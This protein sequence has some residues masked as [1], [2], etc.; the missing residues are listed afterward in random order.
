[1][2]LPFLELFIL[3]SK[4]V[5]TF[6]VLFSSLLK[7]LFFFLR[8]KLFLKEKNSTILLVMNSFSFYMSKEDFNA[9]SFLKDIFTGYS[10]LGWQFFS[11]CTFKILL[12]CLLT[13][14]VSNMKSVTFI[15]VPF[16]EM[17]LFS[18]VAFQT[19]SF[20]LVLSHFTDLVYF[21]SC[22]LC[23]GLIEHLQFVNLV[24]LSSTENFGPLCLNNFCPPAD[25]TD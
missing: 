1:M 25:F 20:L 3:C 5:F 4:F 15:F 13:W 23:F 10:V 14:T 19:F 12:H 11:L 9:P 18:L 24:F 21:S 8:K 22:F 2:Q 6:L 7:Q 17:W 16:C